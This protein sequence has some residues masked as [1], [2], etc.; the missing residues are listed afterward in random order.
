MFELTKE[1][2]DNLRCQIDTSSWGGT[3]YKPMAF[4]EQGE[5]VVFISIAMGIGLA[6]GDYVL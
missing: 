4:T 3:R 1:E 5:I 2:F 6:M